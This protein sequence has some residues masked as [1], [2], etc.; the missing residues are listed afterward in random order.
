MLEV[1]LMSRCSVVL[2]DLMEL[3]LGKVEVLLGMRSVEL[4]LMSKA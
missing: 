3:Q 4:L 1:I 2:R